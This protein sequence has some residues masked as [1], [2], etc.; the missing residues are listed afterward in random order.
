MTPCPHVRTEGQIIRVDG[1]E[2]LVEGVSNREAARNYMKTIRDPLRGLR[3]E[4]RNDRTAEEADMGVRIRGFDIGIQPSAVDQYV[5]V[6][7]EYED[8]PLPPRTARFAAY[9]LPGRG[10]QSRRT[11]DA[12]SGA[13]ITASVSSLQLLLTTSSSQSVQLDKS[14]C[15]NWVRVWSNSCDLLNVQMTIVASIC[16]AAP[17]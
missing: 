10:S 1:H 11:E 12:G 7:P 14:T 3:L 5:V 9:D 2:R 16:L 4:P 15:L 6:R 17:G 8:R 13:R